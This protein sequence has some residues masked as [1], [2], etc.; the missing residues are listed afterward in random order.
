MTHA[1]LV[2]QTLTVWIH[3]GLVGNALAVWIY[4]SLMGDTLVACGFT[5]TSWGTRSS[6]G[7]TRTSWEYRRILD[8]REPRVLTH[9]NLVG[10]TLAVL[11]YRELH[12][13]YVMHQATAA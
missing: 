9:E 1:T 4:E 8:L 10:H 7:F 12:G 11:T 2:V 3:E 6:C 13:A 5:G